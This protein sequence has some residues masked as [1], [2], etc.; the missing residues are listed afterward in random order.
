MHRHSMNNVNIRG[1]SML[2]IEY[3][4]CC[5]VMGEMHWVV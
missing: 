5:F 1:D 2:A 4:L 3:R